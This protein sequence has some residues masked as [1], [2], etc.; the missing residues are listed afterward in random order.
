MSRSVYISCD[1]DE[2]D[3]PTVKSVQGFLNAQ[4]CNV[5]F[6]PTREDRGFYKALEKAIESC[7]AF[8]AIVGDG[9]TTSTGLNAELHYANALRTHRILKRPRIFGMRINQLDLPNCSANITV[10]WIDEQSYKLLLEDILLP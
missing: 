3:L 10:E 8:V 7:D 1:L 4:G 5:E 6:A 9:Y 2:R